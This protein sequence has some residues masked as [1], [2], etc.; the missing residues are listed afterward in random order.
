MFSNKDGG[1]ITKDGMMPAFA[2]LKTKQEKKVCLELSTVE[3]ASM[4]SDGWTSKAG[5]GHT[6]IT[7]HWLDSTFRMRSCVLGAPHIKTSSS[8]VDLDT[9]IR[10]RL[11]RFNFPVER[12][13]TATIDRGG[14]LPKDDS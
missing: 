7:L 11:E 13:S 9:I 14:Q 6:T 10:Q 2:T 8:S 12:I 5:H 3:K 4:T 1:S